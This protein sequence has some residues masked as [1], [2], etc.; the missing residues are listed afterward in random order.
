MAKKEGFLK[1]FFGPVEEELEESVEKNKKQT[2]GEDKNKKARI[3][4]FGDQRVALSRKDSAKGV[5][6]NEVI[7]FK[8]ESLQDCTKLGDWIF[9]EKIIVLNF[10]DIETKVAQRI[11]DFIS[12]ALYV[13]GAS[14]VEMGKNVQCCVPNS[15]VAVIDIPGYQ[16]GNEVFL[17]ENELRRNEVEEIKPK[18]KDGSK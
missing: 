10:E 3:I 15:Y 2:N 7:F 1:T 16:S 14:L 18:Y 17:G 9:N 8:P 13:K 4:N 11:I 6:D 5:Y 12:G